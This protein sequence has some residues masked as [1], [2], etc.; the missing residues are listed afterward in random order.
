[1]VRLNNGT[2]DIEAHAHAIGLGTEKGLKHPIQNRLGYARTGIG[3]PNPQHARHR[4]SFKIS[5]DLNRRG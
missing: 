4:A 3:Y 5:A 1:M 2:A